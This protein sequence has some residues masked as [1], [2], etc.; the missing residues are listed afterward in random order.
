MSI[1]LKVIISVIVVLFLGTF[2][3]FY[4]SYKTY[5]NNIELISKKAILTAKESFINL[6]KNDLKMMTALI[7]ELAQNKEIKAAFIA[8]D[9]NK[10]IQ[11]TES[12]Y[13]LFKS[14]YGIKQWNFIDASLE[15]HMVL[16]MTLPNVFGDPISRV[17]LKNAVKS[18]Q[19]ATGTELGNTAFA[20]RV[21]KPWYDNGKI[22][23]Y[24]ELGEDIILF[25]NILKE[26]TGNEFGI[27][28]NKQL[29]SAKEWETARASSN[30]GNNWN[31]Q[32]EVVVAT[33]TTKDDNFLKY[34][35][36]IEDIFENGI[37]LGEVQ[38]QDSLYIKGIFPIYDVSNQ[39]VG[40]VFVLQNI[41]EIYSG[42]KNTQYKTFFFILIQAILICLI[43]I[44][45]MYRL[46]FLRL[47]NMIEKATRV[48][49]GDYNSPIVSVSNDEVGQFETLF[50]QFR[51]VFVSILKQLEEKEN[52]I[53]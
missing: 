16:R 15:N 9:R 7:E 37:I 32:K 23:G 51:I 4:I 25:S 20:I 29:L 26:L 44:F 30:L 41:T 46:I 19:N 8:R 35:G 11:L 43:L 48:V 14:K 45:I 5:K 10:L 17:T 53:E 3:L 21:V 6:Q 40:A 22:I 24:M 52:H 13:K 28:L 27:L 50:E 47:S 18:G 49:G 2:A 38:K 1:K 33:N 42:M 31:D 39:K 12:R 36:K 34:D